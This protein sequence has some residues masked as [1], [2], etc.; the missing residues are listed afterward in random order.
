MA[1]WLGRL[2]RRNQR[3]R[4]LLFG[5]IIALSLRPEGSLGIG[6]LLPLAG[7]CLVFA[8]TR[9]L[10]HKWQVKKIGEREENTWSFVLPVVHDR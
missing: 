5:G 7:P 9:Y 2:R 6:L 8:A 3:V 4:G 1:A 10:K